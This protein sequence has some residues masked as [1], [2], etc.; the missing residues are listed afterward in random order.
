MVEEQYADLVDA[1]VIDIENLRRETGQNP[2]D[3][4]FSTS[5]WRVG[6]TV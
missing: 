3:R 1:G 4:M 5:I 2:T 6:P